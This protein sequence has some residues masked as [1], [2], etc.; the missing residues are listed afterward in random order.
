V[1]FREFWC[2]T[3]PQQEFNK[4]LHSHVARGTKGEWTLKLVGQTPLTKEKETIFE[5]FIRIKINVKKL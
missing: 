4:Q 5:S 1:I 3:S 2:L